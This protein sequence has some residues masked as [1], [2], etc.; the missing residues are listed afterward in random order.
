M[1]NATLNLSATGHLYYSFHGTTNFVEVT[2]LVLRISS[3]FPNDTII[4][5]CGV[6]GANWVEGQNW[7]SGQYKERLR[8]EDIFFE[9]TK[10]FHG[11]A[12]ICVMRMPVESS[13]FTEGL[14]YRFNPKL[15]FVLA[16]CYSQYDSV[17]RKF[18]RDNPRIV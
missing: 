15:H 1:P 2:E 5:V 4:V 9:L 12:N 13:A 3:S 16:Y 14:N 10:A 18:L 6:H 17:F 7:D 11:I 8:D